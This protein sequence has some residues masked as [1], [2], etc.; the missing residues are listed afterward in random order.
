MYLYI[1]W[2]LACIQNNT[3]VPDGQ[4]IQRHCTTKCTCKNQEFDCVEQTCLLDGPT[5][6]ISGDPHYQTFDLRYFS[7]VGDCE[8]VVSRPC[9]ND[10]FIISVRNSLHNDSAFADQVTV[11]G[12][13]ITIVLGR[14]NGGTI[15]IDGNLQDSTVDGVIKKNGDVQVI[16]SG[17]H[18]NVI[19]PQLGVRVT[20]NGLYRVEITV[21]TR[22]RNQLC[23]LCGNYNDDFGDDNIGPDGTEYTNRE[24][25]IEDFANSWIVGSPIG[26]QFSLSELCSPDEAGGAQ[27]RCGEL[28]GSF[29][30]VC[31]QVVSP[32]GFID[33][34]I[35]DI[36]NCNEDDVD[37]CYCNSLAT[38]AA[39][40]AAAGV[41]LPDWRGFYECCKCK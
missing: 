39:A 19:F 37:E 40:C 25:R 13:G 35:I 21:S 9:N 22:W 26:C 38:Y 5:C 24:S 34:C 15:T 29:F 23:G 20:W 14:G 30:S 4:Q 28:R 10:S 2:H 41:I 12:A 33:N 27:V 11:Q 3:F 31:N 32:S 36:C 1:S 16:Q 6:V 7:F 8:Y 17:G 18:P